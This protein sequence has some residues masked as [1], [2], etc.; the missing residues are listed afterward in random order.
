M[1]FAALLPL[2]VWA[3]PKLVMLAEGIFSWGT[4][5]G[6][7]KKEYVTTSLKTIVDGFQEKTTGGA[8]TSWDNLAPSIDMLIEGAVGI[9]NAVGFFEDEN[10]SISRGA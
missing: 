1:T 7:Q 8:K 3:V 9:G 5:T 2:I 6:T 4:K 10:A